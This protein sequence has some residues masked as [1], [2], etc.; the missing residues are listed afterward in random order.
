VAPPKALVVEDAPEIAVVVRSMLQ[1]EGY[2]VTVAHDGARG[3]AAARSE[4]PELVVLDLSLPDADGVEICRELRTFS[5]AYVV[6]VTARDDEVDKVVGLTVGADDYI[7]KPFSP[8]E[9]SARIRAMRRRPRATPQP[10][11]VEFDNLSIDTDAREVT[12]DGV[13][14]GLTKIEYDLLVLL[15]AS[16]RRT[17]TRT[18]LLQHIWGEWYGNDHVI[19]VHLGNLRKKLG[20]S[21][22]RPRFIRTVR[23]V[24]YRF[25][26]GAR[27]S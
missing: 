13:D 11:L 10:G 12:L 23:G 5:D 8:R 20:E 6:M 24:G 15:A 3:L 1:K 7:T 21:A 2:D 27:T 19:D 16:P 25:E 18:Q 17:H 22:S 14:L 26:P 9:L 4:R